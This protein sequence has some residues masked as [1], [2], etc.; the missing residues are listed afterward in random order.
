MV[1]H[2]IWNIAREGVS[3]VYFNEN[4]KYESSLS[5]YLWR[6]IYSLLRKRRIFRRKKRTKKNDNIYL[7]C[8]DFEMN[9]KANNSVIWIS[10][11]R[12]RHIWFLFCKCSK[13]YFNSTQT[14]FYVANYILL[15][16]GNTIMN[17]ADLTWAIIKR[18]SCNQDKT[19]QFD[20][21]I[22]IIWIHRLT[23]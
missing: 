1:T 16:Q 21:L 9:K 3:A 6:H 15:T 19:C 2:R 10:D 12:Y 7:W 22:L 14:T 5:A 20:E 4:K 23:H 18:K 13:R 17:I 8:G 11:R